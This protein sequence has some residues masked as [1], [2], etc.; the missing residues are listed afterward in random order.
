MSCNIVDYF[1]DTYVNEDTCTYAPDLWETFSA[2]DELTTNCCE[3]FHRKLNDLVY[4]KHPNIFIFIDAL[5]CIQIDTYVKLNSLND[6]RVKRN[7]KQKK[8]KMI[9]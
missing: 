5:K 4:V 9:I 2:S 1:C 8:K 3:A 7:K 6:T